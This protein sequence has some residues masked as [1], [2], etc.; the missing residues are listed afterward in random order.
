MKSHNTPTLSGIA[1]Y[2]SGYADGEGCF[3][4][5]FSHRPKL[6]VGW[7]VKPSFAVGQNADRAEVLALMQRYFKCGFIRAKGADKTVK[8]EVRSIED[9][10]T[11]VL[12]HFAKY[13]LRSSK[14]KDVKLLTQICVAMK[15]RQHLNANGLKRI[16]NLAYQMNGSGKRKYTKDEILNRLR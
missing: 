8:Y 12:V 4:V 9:L 5:S 2:L 15:T 14:Q 6:T 1:H 11:K 10:V 13:P 7:E 3:S 16:I